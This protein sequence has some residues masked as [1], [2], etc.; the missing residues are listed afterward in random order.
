M[1]N[2]D[3]HI[4]TITTKQDIFTFISISIIISNIMIVYHIVILQ[5]YFLAVSHIPKFMYIHSWKTTIIKLN[6][7]MFRRWWKINIHVHVCLCSV[8]ESFI[9]KSFSVHVHVCQ[10]QIC[11]YC[12]IVLQFDWLSLAYLLSLSNSTSI[13]LAVIGILVVICPIV[14]QFLLAVSGK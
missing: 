3:Y 1:H 5:Y 8:T 14:I 6:Y 4:L 13:W 11:T 7:F 10:S 12:Q 2:F 9:N